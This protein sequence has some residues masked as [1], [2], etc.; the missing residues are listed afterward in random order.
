MQK[1]FQIRTLFKKSLID[2]Q[3]FIKLAQISHFHKKRNFFKKGGYNWIHFLDKLLLP[4][5]FHSRDI[6]FVCL[7]V[8]WGVC[9]FV[10]FFIFASC[11]PLSHQSST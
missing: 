3:I 4:Y 11:E 2:Y 7:F 1:D 5:K 10:C 9:L 8:C 6:V